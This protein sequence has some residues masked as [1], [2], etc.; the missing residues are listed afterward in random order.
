MNEIT[1][2][3]VNAFISYSHNDAAIVKNLREHFIHSIGQD[4]IRLWFDREI[5]AGVEWNPEIEQHL[6]DSEL[7]L[8]CISH[9]FLRSKACMEEFRKSINM[10]EENNIQIV[11]IIVDDCEWKDYEEISKYQALPEYGTPLNSFVDKKEVFAQIEVALNGKV[12][13]ILKRRALSLQSAH[14]VWLNDMDPLLSV[15]GVEHLS[16][17]LDDVYIDPELEDLTS[18]DAQQNIILGSDIVSKLK[19]GEHVIVVGEDQSGK[20]AICKKIFM[21]LFARH[22]FPVFLTAEN[23]YQENPQNKKQ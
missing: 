9:S 13:I 2:E 18:S 11:P 15:C 22:Y 4:R 6:S 19:N 20:T 8:F 5:E 3:P 10:K 16:L 7:V 12:D 1:T 23:K 14:R 17:H 21:E